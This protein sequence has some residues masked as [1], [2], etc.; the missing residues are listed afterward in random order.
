VE[1]VVGGWGDVILYNLITFFIS[2]IEEKE[3]KAITLS[4][5]R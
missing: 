4:S 5:F 1:V 2:P 3:I